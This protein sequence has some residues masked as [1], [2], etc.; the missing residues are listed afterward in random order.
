MQEL[1]EKRHGYLQSGRKLIRFKLVN[2]DGLMS[3]Y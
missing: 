1:L 2:P 3:A